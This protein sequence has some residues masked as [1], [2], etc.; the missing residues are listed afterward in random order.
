MILY[1]KDKDEKN[2]RK[3]IIENEKNTIIL[4]IDSQ[5]VKKGILTDTMQRFANYADTVAPKEK[6]DSITFFLNNFKNSLAIANTNIFLL[7]NLLNLLNELLNIK[8]NKNEKNDKDDKEFFEK[9]DKYNVSFMEANEIIL[10]NTIQI[11]Q[12]LSHI[13][14]FSEF[15]FDSK[16]KLNNL[17]TNIA[18]KNLVNLNVE[19][20]KVIVDT[21]NINNIP[22]DESLIQEFD[23]EE[24]PE[25][26]LVVSEKEGIVLL[27]FTL[28]E[29]NTIYSENRDKYTSFKQIIEEKFT[30]KLDEYRNPALARFREAFKLMRIKEKASVIKAFELGMELFF[31]YNLHPAIISACKSLDELD[32]YLDYLEDN[33]THKFDCFKIIFDMAPIEV[34]SNK[35]FGRKN[36]KN[37]LSD[38]ETAEEILAVELESQTLDLEDIKEEIETENDKEKNKK[39]DK[40]KDENKKS[41]DTDLNSTSMNIK[42]LENVSKEEVEVTVIPNKTSKSKGKSKL[43]RNEDYNLYENM[44]EETTKK[45]DIEDSKFKD[46]NDTISI[47]E[48][49]MSESTLEM[50][51]VSKIVVPKEVKKKRVTKSK[52]KVKV[53]KDSKK[54]EK[55]ETKEESKTENK[56]KKIEK[57]KEDKSEKAEKPE[58]KKVT[59]KVTKTKVKSDD[60]KDNKAEKIEKEEKVVKT[61]KA[62]KVV[63]KK[64]NKNA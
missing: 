52:A 38:K 33:E 21:T 5:N 47:V 58:T 30:V 31:N 27:P 29:I 10:N 57:K 35:L 40:L 54:E 18:N 43:R 19:E 63:R 25:N 45:V 37:N 6:N 50:P 56:S 1:S 16:N 4:M 49:F 9:L 59:K 26:T 39:K 42:E 48:D 60:K 8:E 7:N 61:T 34:K 14:S 12:T 46:V 15:A 44:M 51:E 64:V 2:T 28:R 20:N 53:S 23:K 22:V 17:I 32:I 24:H 55:V 36:K 13:L 11:E 62:K 3:D 41:F